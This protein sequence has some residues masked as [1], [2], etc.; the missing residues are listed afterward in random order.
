MANGG[1]TLTSQADGEELRALSRKSMECDM[2][3]RAGSTGCPFSD[4]LGSYALLVRG[5]KVGGYR[6]IIDGYEPRTSHISHDS[7]PTDMLRAPHRGDRGAGMRAPPADDHGPSR[8]LPAL[9]R[10]LIFGA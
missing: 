10:V 1:N 5:C 9:C 6:G 2:L 3:M 4:N 8:G 7:T